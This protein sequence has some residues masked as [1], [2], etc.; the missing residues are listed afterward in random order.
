M[1]VVDV[2]LLCL[3]CKPV[4]RVV[5]EHSRTRRRRGLLY[6]FRDIGYSSKQYARR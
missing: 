3:V 6:E 5:R 4:K 2:W 1:W